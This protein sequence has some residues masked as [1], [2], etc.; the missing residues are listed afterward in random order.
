MS[1]IA[2][3]WLTL[4]L[5]AA[6]NPAATARLLMLAS[7]ALAL[8]V[9]ATVT[10]AAAPAIAGACAETAIIAALAVM[11]LALWHGTT[12]ALAAV[13]A[14]VLLPLGATALA[15]TGE[16][17]WLPIGL[18]AAP[19][20]GI[21]AV[22]THQRAQGWIAATG[23]SVSAIAAGA[24]TPL[25]GIAA[26]AIMAVG[27]ALPGQLPRGLP[28]L[29]TLPFLLPIAATL[30]ARGPWLLAPLCAGL[31]LTAFAVLRPRP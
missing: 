2:A 26:A 8:F 24:G 15:T 21:G 29:L 14:V 6:T 27:A 13:I 23:L 19:L 17:D 28:L 25:P 5:L 16:A 9:L 22:A 11:P 4:F 18:F 7:I 20:A 12:P 10:A 3:A 1:A 30:A 31:G